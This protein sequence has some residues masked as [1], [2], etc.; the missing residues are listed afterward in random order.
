MGSGSVNAFGELLGVSLRDAPA[1]ADDFTAET[2]A[3]LEFRATDDTWITTGLGTRFADEAQ[4]D[5]IFVIAGLRWNV[6]S[7]PSFGR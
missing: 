1:G 5:K 6:S 3:G 2:S 4:P 7:G